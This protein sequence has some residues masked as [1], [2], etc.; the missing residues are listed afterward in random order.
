MKLHYRRKKSMQ[1]EA[2]SLS[3]LFA[4]AETVYECLFTVTRISISV[5]RPACFRP[6]CSG[7]NLPKSHVF[8][9]QRVRVGELGLGFGVGWDVGDEPLFEGFDLVFTAEMAG[10]DNEAID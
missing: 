5:F 10:V 3:S 6:N 2:E 7:K 9:P 8:T 4:W 1:A